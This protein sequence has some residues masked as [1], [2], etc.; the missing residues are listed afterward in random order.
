MN[1]AVEVGPLRMSRESDG[2]RLY[3][4]RSAE[5]IAELPPNFER[6]VSARL[7]E[8]LIA[9]PA[10]VVLDL[11][12]ATGLS[13]RELGVLLAVRKALQPQFERLPLRRVS[14]AVR[15]LL[16]MTHVD[17]FFTVD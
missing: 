16:E 11:Q 14:P 10:P 9:S 17:R 3:L 6:D 13:S 1:P 12:D 7:H 2:W 8:A 4:S 15:R 5:L